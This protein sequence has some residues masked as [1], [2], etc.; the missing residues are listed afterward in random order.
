VRRARKLAALARAGIA[1]LLPAPAAAAA[2]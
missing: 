2:A 1:A